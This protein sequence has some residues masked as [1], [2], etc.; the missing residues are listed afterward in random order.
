MTTTASR[1]L[2]AAFLACAAFVPTV[3]AQDKAEHPYIDKLSHAVYD[4]G[5]DGRVTETITYRFQVLQES[6]LERSKMFTV[7]Y[8]TSIQT[9]EILEAYTLKKDGRQ[10][11]VPA[12]NY[13]VRTNEGRNKA[14]PMFSDRASVSVVLPDLAVGDSVHV[15][16]RVADRE[17]MFPGHFSLAQ[18]FSPY[19]VYE[20]TRVTVR[21]PK[22]MKVRTEAHF[23]Q[24][25]PARAEGDKTVLEWRFRNLQPPRWSEED[26]GV[27]TQQEVPSVLVSTFPSYEAIAQAYG[28]R[29]TPKAQPTDRVRELVRQTLAGETRPREKA[30]L[31]YE[32]V[33]RNLT[34]GGNCIGVGAVVP[35]DIEVILDN[36]MGDC[37]DHATLLQA[38]LTAAGIRSEQVLINASSRYDLAATPVASLVNHVMNYLP[39]FDLYVDATAKEI[40]FGYLPE[41]TYAKPVIHVGAAKALAK[42]PAEKPSDAQQKLHMTLEMVENGSA[43]GTMRVSLKGVAAA[44]VRAM[45]RDLTADQERDFVKSSLADYRYRGRGTLEKGNIA[46]LSDSYEYSV[47]FQVDN[48]LRGGSTGAFLFSPV[49]GSPMPV[50][51]F[52]DAEERVLAKRPERCHGFSTSETYEIRLPVGL[53]L[54]SMP[55][56]ATVRSSLLEYSASYR[57]DGDKVFV[58]RDLNDKTTHGI[59]PPDVM[60]E[61]NKQALPI[62]ENL[63]TQV[64][65]KRQ[66]R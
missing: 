37:K 57:K 56:P 52:S 17:P 61:F 1:L 6:L 62:G 40:P 5:S 46:G 59:C 60:R 31:L 32:W 10:V 45:H 15:R 12:G 58:Q 65:Y 28:E 9:G 18:S 27:W 13:Q 54:L 34:Y 44:Y 25:V 43:F 21:L 20:D 63:R 8:S 39:E 51:L 24:A 53:T 38:M 35:R 64:L 29:A 33:S 7:S 16:Y 30:R 41:S 55:E 36:K 22:D 50:S 14:G 48:F 26:G 19:N 66:P 23:L 42:V 47:K 49:M 2:A 11:P 3:R 4:V